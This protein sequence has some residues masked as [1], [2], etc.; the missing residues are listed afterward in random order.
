MGFQMGFQMALGS[1]WK[2]VLRSSEL[3]SE[4]F[5]A[6]LD[7]IVVEVHKSS[8]V[9]LMWL[10]VGSIAFELWLSFVILGGF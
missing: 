10:S 9:K 3:Y 8:A 6:L 5:R 4:R 1:V 2:A 7:F